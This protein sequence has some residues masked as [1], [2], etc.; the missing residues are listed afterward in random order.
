MRDNQEL[1]ADEARV[2]ACV[3][4]SKATTIR[5]L[6]NLV[7]HLQHNMQDGWL[8][9]RVCVEHKS[10]LNMEFVRGN[11]KTFGYFMPGQE[12]HDLKKAVKRHISL[13]AHNESCNLA[14]SSAIK[15]RK[16]RDVALSLARNAYLAITEKLGYVAYE[17]MVM[18]DHLNG[19]VVGNVNHSR[20]F[21]SKFVDSMY[22]VLVHSVSLFL[23]SPQDSI[24]GRQPPF[25]ILADK[26]TALGRTGQAIGILIMEFGVVRAVMIA[27]LPVGTKLGGAD[28]AKNLK[29]GLE[30]YKLTPEELKNQLTAQAYDGAYFHDSVPEHLCTLLGLDIKW[31]YGSWDQAH[32]LELVAGDLRKCLTTVDDDLVVDLNMDPEGDEPATTAWYARVA[33]QVGDVLSKY[34]YGKTYEELLETAKG[35]AQRLRKPKKFCDTRFLQAE[36]KVYESYLKNWNIIYAHLTWKLTE[37]ETFIRNKRSITP[38]KEDQAT[39]DSLVSRLGKHKSFALIAEL[40]CLSDIFAHIKAISLKY[41]TVNVLP[42]ELLEA[43][44]G[45]HTLLNS[46]GAELLRHCPSL[47]NFPYLM[48]KDRLSLRVEGKFCDVMLDQVPIDEADGLLQNSVGELHQVY[49]RA[50]GFCYAFA[51]GLQTRLLDRATNGFVEV[52]GN[53]MDMRKFIF[54]ENE[55]ANQSQ[56]ESLAKLH[57]AMTDAGLQNLPTLHDLCTQHLLVKKRLFEKYADLNLQ[58][59]QKLSG[60]D[61]TP[62]MFTNVAFQKGVEDWLYVFQHCALKT[63]NEAVVEGMG[64]IVD[65]HATP[66]RHLSME[67]YAKEAIIDYNGPLLHEADAFLMASV[68]RYF[69]RTNANGTTTVQPHHFFHKQAACF[70]KFTYSKVIDHRLD[71]RSKLDFA[72]MQWYT[73]ANP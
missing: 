41:Q 7:P 39:L 11:F 3:D 72:T 20:K 28:V 22:T 1:A 26:M 29:L 68:D 69:T 9:C 63:C 71:E 21:A 13:T 47:E 23:H 24:G 51:K 70:S 30:P 55:G 67:A 57:K 73:S 36:Y 48:H 17:R 35:F 15:G 37:H 58:M 49:D 38:S 44:K 59:K 6:V 65:Q 12:F 56:R 64:C 60:T 8:Q 10:D 2:T 33:I 16:N 50:G 32:I 4:I 27:H 62:F 66:G 31:S 14:D 45:L 61:I 34:N 18:K 46:L 40:S 42:W 5:Q 54:E 43:S 52:M 53:C 25:A 19:V